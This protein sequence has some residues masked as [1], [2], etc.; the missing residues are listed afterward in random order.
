MIMNVNT[1]GVNITFFRVSVFYLYFSRNLYFPKSRGVPS[2]RTLGLYTI[3]CDLLNKQI[4]I[5]ITPFNET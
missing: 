3:I 1:K 4:K 2:L 5:C